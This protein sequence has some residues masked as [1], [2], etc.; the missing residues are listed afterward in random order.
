MKTLP[1][2]G[3]LALLLV[4][5]ATAVQPTMKT[6]KLFLTPFY[7]SGMTNG[8]NHTSTL[9][10]DPPDGANKITSAILTYDLWVTPTVNLTLWVNG[11]SCKNYNYVINTTYAAA[12]R[13]VATY[14]CSNIITKPG[15]YAVTMKPLGANT[16]P[17]TAWADLTYRNDPIGSVTVSGTE[18]EPGDPA[19]IF[20]QLSDAQGVAINNASCYLDIWYP[21]SNGT[22]PYTLIDAPMLLAIGDDGVYYYD[23]VAPATLG[24]YMLSAKCA[25]AYNTVM[26]YPRTENI[27]FPNSTRQTG[28][29]QGT[30]LALNSPTDELY[31]RCDGSIANPCVSNYTF[32]TSA[33]GVLPNITS[34]NVYYSG[35]SDTAGRTLLLAWWNGTAWKNMTNNLS[36]SGTGGSVPTDY[37][38]LLTNNIPSTAI[39]NGGTVK[40]QLRVE[41]SDRIF[42]NWLTLGI[43]SSTGTVQQ[44]KG[45]S[46]MHITNH[47]GSLNA[48]LT[49]LPASI[50]NYTTRNL[51]YY[52]D[53]TNYTLIAN[54]TWSYAIR[55]LTFFPTIDYLLLQ[56]L[57]WNAT[58]RNLTYYPNAGNAT[59]YTL[60]AEDVWAYPSRYTHGEII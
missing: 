55:N 59:N 21:L 41:G 16:G 14:D 46:E 48:S 45:S 1:I 15:S 30:S 9:T 47:T 12:G 18:Y 2:I 23:M 43:I 26:I 51:T 33:Y 3:I 4:A 49:L 37:D 44:V 40:I 13:A 34:I 54:T 56:T 28:T 25:Y 27:L 8:A 10:F 35:Q 29:W 22:H 20:L 19:T 6:D 60:I 52:E 50:W 31:E 53:V 57:I 36:L 42:H 7:R 17:G 5:T 24:V 38:E 58:D 39:V 32:N 11:Q